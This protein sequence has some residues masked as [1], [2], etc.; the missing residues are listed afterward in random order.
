MLIVHSFERRKAS[1]FSRLVRI[2]E[3]GLFICVYRALLDSGWLDNI[4]VDALI[5]NLVDQNICLP[6][7]KQGFTL[8]QPDDDATEKLI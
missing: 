4:L 1:W 5:E 2:R 7:S 6:T 8:I 3:K